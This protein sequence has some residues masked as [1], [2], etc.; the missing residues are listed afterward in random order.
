MKINKIKNFKDYR[1]D[2]FGNVYSSKRN[3]I[4]K[5][6]KNHNGYLVVGLNKNLKTHNFLVHRLIAE[7]FIPNPENYPIIN[8]KDGNKANNNI[9]NLEWCTYSH[10]LKHAYDNKLRV[11]AKTMLGKFGSK[12][13]Q[14]KMVNQICPM[15]GK[16]IKKWG[17]MIDVANF[18]GVHKSTLSP[19][20]IN[21]KLYKG[22][23]WRYA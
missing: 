18:L 16:T 2:I 22:F 15:S 13:N 3:I 11:A 5:Q 14:S 1:I 8:H 4:L 23:Y 21:N 7:Y 10:N 12:H 19:K 9:S 17:S 20:V 6:Y